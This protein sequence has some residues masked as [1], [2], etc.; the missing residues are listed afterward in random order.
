M[1][2]LDD[3]IAAETMLSEVDGLNGRLVICGQRLDELA[4]HRSYEEVLGLLGEGFLPG[5]QT[6]KTRLGMARLRAFAEVSWLD[7]ALLAL[8]VTEGLRALMAR[9]VDGEDVDTALLL[10]AAPAVFVPAL[11][12][13][14]AG[15]SA[16]APDPSLGHAA[17]MLAM[18]KG[19]I[20]LEAD[21]AALDTY[22]VTVSDHGLNASTF[23]ARVVASTRAGYTSAV[24]AALG[25]TGGAMAGMASEGRVLLPVT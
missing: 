5:G 12:R 7:D 20:P 8:S 21:V 24:L 23:A 15:L 3:V 6:L 10:A 11:V 22:L 1:S 25:A 16:I 9:L 19:E 17:D 2:G 13:R 18:L 4:G 14:K